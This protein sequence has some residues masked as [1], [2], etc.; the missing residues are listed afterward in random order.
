[1][2]ERKKICLDAGHGGK[3]SGALGPNGLRESDVALSVVML[4]GSMLTPYLDVTYTRKTDVFIELSGRASIANDQQA[5]A[6]LSIHCNSG[7]Q[8]SGDGFE[9]FTSPGETNSDRLATCLFIPY[10]AKFPMKR[11]RMDLSDADED[12]EA[13]FTVLT[14]TRMAAAL[15]EL[16]FIHTKEGEAWLKDPRNQKACAE[17]LMPGVLDYFGIA[18]EPVVAAP[19]VNPKAAILAK[20]EELKSLVNAS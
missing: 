18:M 5:D 7:G 6:F 19:V 8:G 2:S 12:K 20:I 16:E 1:M 3:D 11:K 10:G 17:A 4:L 15:F 14:R 9:V 13:S